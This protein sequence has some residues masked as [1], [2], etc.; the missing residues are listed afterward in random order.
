MPAGRPAA[1]LKTPAV[2]GPAITS[3][4]TKRKEAKL[5]Q[6]C[7]LSSTAKPTNDGNDLH[8][9]FDSDYSNTYL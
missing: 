5:I 1:S 4:S 2:R 7:P 9:E 8:R 3:L 6:D